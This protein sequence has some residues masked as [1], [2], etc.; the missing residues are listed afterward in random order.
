MTSEMTS[1]DF[2]VEATINALDSALQAAVDSVPGCIS[3]G[4]VDLATGML[5]AIKSADAHPR[6]A[7][8]LLAVATSDLFQGRNAAL[9]EDIM[10]R[11]RGVPEP[12]RGFFQ[13]ITVHSDH[14][15]HIFLRGKK[16][17]QVAAFI[18]RKDSSV[19][20]ALAGARAAM[21]A[22]EAVF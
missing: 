18:C 7:N 15:L 12:G 19:D 1:M 22:I 8:E 16:Q 5:L 11:A 4:Y 20:A 13:E 10:R 14:S 21:P 2:A 9:I 6:E 3:A 17:N